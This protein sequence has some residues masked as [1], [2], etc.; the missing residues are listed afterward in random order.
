MS[1]YGPRIRLPSLRIPKITLPK[2]NPKKLKPLFGII[3]I[4]LLIILFFSFTDLNTNNS[5]KVDWKNN[6]LKLTSETGLYAKLNITLT[7]TS[8]KITDLNLIVDSVSKEII[9]FC[10]TNHFPNVDVGDIRK[11]SCIV[12]RNPNEKIYPGTY[13]IKIKTNLGERKTSLNIQTS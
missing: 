13:T 12:R 3:I 11:A 6:P 8:K 7:N 2:I 1:I 4:L 9:I 10:E 5:I